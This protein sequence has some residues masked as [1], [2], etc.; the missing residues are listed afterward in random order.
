MDNPLDDLADELLTRAFLYDDPTSFRAGVR[1]AIRALN[2][3]IER[4]G[5]RAARSHLDA[6]TTAPEVV[7]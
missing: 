3:S 1:G 7:A 4:K 5:K 2:A 6:P